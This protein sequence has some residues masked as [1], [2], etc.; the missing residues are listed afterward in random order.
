MSVLD[1]I[2]ARMDTLTNKQRSIA[3]YLLEVP[4][5]ASYLSLKELSQRVQASEVSILRMCKAL[6]YDSFV[7]L[8]EALRQHTQE[9]LQAATALPAFLAQHGNRTEGTPEQQLAQICMDDQNNLADMISRLD[10]DTLFQCAGSLLDAHEVLVFAH[11]RSSIFADY[12]CYRLNFLQIKAS[13]VQLGNSESISTALARLKST[14]AVIIFSFPPYHMPIQNIV[15][16]CQYRGTPVFA[17]TDSMDSPA[18]TTDSHVFICRTGARY[19]YNSHVTTLSFINVLASCIALK[20]GPKFEQILANEQD[21]NEFLY[22][23]GEE[24]EDDRV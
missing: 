9:T 18:A 15:S 13:P 5:V 4:E 22:S 24:K 23:I 3:Q 17:I 8:K 7:S 12:L 6:G 1:T 14:D 21:V 19:F 11:D 20:M 10:P 2:R 16:Y